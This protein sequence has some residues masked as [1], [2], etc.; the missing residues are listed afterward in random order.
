MNNTCATNAPDKIRALDAADPL[1]HKRAEFVLPDD[2]IYLDGNSLGPLS[3]RAKARVTE[4]VADE[5]GQDLI[6]SWN[7][8]HW[9]D[10]PTSVGEKIAPLLGAKPEQTICCDSISVNLFKLLAAALQINAQRRVI[11]SQQ[12]NFPTDLYI[13]DGLATLLS[14]AHQLKLA[15]EDDILESLNEEVAVLLLTQVNFRSGSMHDIQAVT[16]RA[17]EVGALVV[18]DL[19]HSAGAVPLQLDDWRVDFAVGCGYKYLNGGPGAPAFIYVAQR[20]QAM[21][22]QP[23]SGWMGHL[24]PFSFSPDFQAADGVQRFLS[25]T[26][27]ILSLAALDGAMDVFADVTV[28]QLRQKS[29]SLGELFIER[30]AAH[31]ELRE[32]TLASPADP[33]VRGSQVSYSHPA[34]FA[35][36]QALIEQRIIVDFR[37]PDIVR[38]GFCPLYVSYQDVWHAVEVL[39]VVLKSALY[40]Q[41]KYQQRSKVT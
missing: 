6:A 4:V 32:L 28:A 37:A 35:I 31:P 38:F 18:W 14:G 23:L 33:Q 10:L 5:W 16:R 20:H 9:I 26:P 1:A 22:L 8:N 3:K 25:G 24:A 12:D 21:A 34:A 40:Q 41:G 11:L 7:T 13:A 30:V 2:T 29:I 27:N 15:A 36:S 39:A 17:H 19:A